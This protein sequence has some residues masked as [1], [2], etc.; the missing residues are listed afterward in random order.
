M[1]SSGKLTKWSERPDL[2][3]RRCG[4][5]RAWIA[6]EAEASNDPYVIAARDD[7]QKPRSH[8]GWLLL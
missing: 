8:V 2:A 4:Q 6:I 5:P 1:R 7:Q 3:E